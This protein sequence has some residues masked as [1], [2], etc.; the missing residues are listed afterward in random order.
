M[1]ICYGCASQNLLVSS[2]QKLKLIVHQE[3]DYGDNKENTPQLEGP[4]AKI[5]NYVLGGLGEIKQKKKITSGFLERV[6]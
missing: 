6:I 4:A 1:V 3:E 5:Y 2:Q